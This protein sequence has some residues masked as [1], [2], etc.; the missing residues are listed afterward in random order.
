M[1]TAVSI[2]QLVD[3]GELTLLTRAVDVLNLGNSRIAPEVTVYHLLTMT[4]VIADWFDE[5]GDLEMEW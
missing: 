1:F 3:K 4:S 5:S 2:L